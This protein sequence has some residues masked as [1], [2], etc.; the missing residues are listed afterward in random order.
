[1]SGTG[2][3]IKYVSMTGDARL[4]GLL[5]GSAWG[6]AKIYYSV[7][8]SYRD[9]GYYYGAGEHDGQFQ[10]T[11]AM[12]AIMD[13]ALAEYGT[14]A[15]GFSVEG[16]TNLSVEFTTRQGAHL[17]LSQTDSDPYGIG[18]AWGYYPSQDDTGGDV[19]FYSGNFDYSAP[20]PGD[21]ASMT[22][23]HEIG[24]ALGLAHGHE[25]NGVDG[26]LPAE[27]DSMEYSVM[28]Y[29]SYVG[30]DPTTGY[31][32][33]TYGYAQSFMMLDIA[34]LQHMYGADFTTNSGNTTYTWTPDSGVTMINGEAAITPG[35]NRIFATIWDGGGID[36]YDLSAY[37]TEVY[38]DL[39]PG[40]HS[41][42][43]YEQLSLLGPDTVARGNIFNALLY[44]GDTRSLI[45]N[46]KG[47][48][49]DD[50]IL[51]NQA[52][53]RLEGNDGND[54]LLGRAGRDTLLGQDGNDV[55]R[56]GGG[57]DLLQGDNGSDRLAGDAGDD[58]LI[59]G[60]GNDLL[61]GGTG[62][63][64]LIGGAGKDILFGEAGAD[65]FRFTAL[66]DSGL[67]KTSDIIRDFTRGNDVIDLSDL[68]DRPIEF[69]T[70]GTFGGHGPSLI[71]KTFQSGVEVL[72]DADG[73][74][75]AD[76]RIVV[77]DVARLSEADFLL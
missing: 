71:A 41:V 13:F 28:T 67:G 8:S 9:Y 51:G 4:D 42:F 3:S 11:G 14:A 40:G 72:L 23:I 26:P 46:V 56:G 5:L 76:F 24:H 30:A 7:P 63:D 32:N 55:L 1:M 57:R 52:N 6:D 74:G 43:S 60:A 59:G 58:R 22:I 48:S 15:D 66:S 17:R 10:V 61:K 31:L 49:G 20:V 38:I 25:G 19:W 68:I 64:V 65:V 12:G 2:K 33:E 36:T 62:K 75:R 34:A 53:N 47:G 16:F 29:R 54:G 50:I 45:E 44:K 35:A 70:D 77:N 27:Y 18:T 69:R 21:Y 73:D 39:T 37:Q